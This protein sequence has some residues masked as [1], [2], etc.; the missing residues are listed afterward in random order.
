MSPESLS[1]PP[2]VT[3]L[4][5]L[6]AILE[7]R[8]IDERDWAILNRRCGLSKNCTLEEI[9]REYKVTRERRLHRHPSQRGSRTEPKQGLWGYETLVGRW[10]RAEDVAHAAV[11]LASELSD[12][13]TGSEI[14]IDGGWL[15]ARP[16]AGEI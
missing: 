4:K 11:F 1:L 6:D 2:R 7:S 13:I 16:R 3:P 15:A 14:K 10:G 8:R 5:D 9:G 12:Y